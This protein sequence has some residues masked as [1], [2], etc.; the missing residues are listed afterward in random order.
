MMLVGLALALEM[1][2]TKKCLDEN[3]RDFAI[4]TDVLVLFRISKDQIFKV[5]KSRE[6]FHFGILL[7]YYGEITE[8][9]AP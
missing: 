6:G 3:I 7:Q 5:A 2:V 8:R 1:T 4:L 9:A